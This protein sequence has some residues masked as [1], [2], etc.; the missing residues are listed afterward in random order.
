MIRAISARRARAGRTASAVAAVAA[1]LMLASSASAAVPANGDITTSRSMQTLFNLVRVFASPSTHA[2]VRS[3][4][5]GSGTGVIVACWTTGKDYKGTPV[6]YQITAPA[7]GYVPA[8]NIAAHFSPATGIPH[9]LIPAFSA[10]YYALEANLRIRTAPSITA[11]ISGYLVS[12]GSKVT[13]NC[14]ADGTPIFGDPVWYHAQ[15]P[16]VG[17]VAGR[18]LNTG[19]DPALGV[20]RC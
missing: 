5:T 20:P 1:T 15:S 19:G 12:I 18:F 14:Y 6:W 4:L 9:C 11:T 16:E 7:A 17:Y 2:E 13:I 10:D 3:H 8:F